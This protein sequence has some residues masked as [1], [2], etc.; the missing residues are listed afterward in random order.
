MRGAGCGFRVANKDSPVDGGI[1]AAE[2]SEDGDESG[3]LH[4][5]KECRGVDVKKRGWMVR[6]VSID[7]GDVTV[8]DEED[9]G[10][11]GWF[12]RALCDELTMGVWSGDLGPG[13]RGA[14][15]GRLGGQ[16]TERSR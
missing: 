3:G 1:D 2:G 10:E 8:G 15:R 16:R 4:D 12:M 11:T 14:G 7:G 9:G 5:V 13:V 6:T